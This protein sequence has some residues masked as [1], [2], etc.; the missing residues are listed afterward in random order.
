MDIFLVSDENRREILS[1]LPDDAAGEDPVLLC[2]AMDEDGEKRPVGVLA[3][4]ITGNSWYISYIAVEREH[5]REG[6]GRALLSSLVNMARGALADEISLE[7]NLDPNADSEID[8]FFD[9]MGFKEVLRSNVY[10]IPILCFGEELKKS[11]KKIP[12]GNFSSLAEIPGRLWE[13]MRRRLIAAGESYSPGSDIP[14]F[15]QRVFI[16]PG[17]RG[18]Y[19]KE[20]SSVFLTDSGS[21]G[22]CMLISGRDGGIVVNYLCSMLNDTESLKGM[23]GLFFISYEKALQK[24][25]KDCKIFVNTQNT[26]SKRLFLKF[27]GGKEELYGVAVER[28]LIF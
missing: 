23:V 18:L 27:T 7:Y 22:G 13:E 9:A 11:V 16:D 5:R 12:K 19:D 1:V 15:E 24:Y 25:G 10:S 6:I 28:E 3:A 26:M 8:L 21:I 17:K 14:V 20:V 2:A 4:T